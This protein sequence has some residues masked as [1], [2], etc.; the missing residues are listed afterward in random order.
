MIEEPRKRPQLTTAFR[1]KKQL[2]DPRDPSLRE[3]P[4]LVNQLLALEFPTGDL[5]APL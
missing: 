2:W 5:S 3:G 1:S 4:V